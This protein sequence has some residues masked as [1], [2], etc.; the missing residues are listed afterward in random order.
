MFLGAADERNNLLR[1]SCDLLSSC[2]SPPAIKRWLADDRVIASLPGNA[3]FIS[4]VL[5]L[6]L[7]MPL[8]VRLSVCLSVCPSVRPSAYSRCA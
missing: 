5:A 8:H 3:V 7:R 6:P 2:L 1:E 4:H